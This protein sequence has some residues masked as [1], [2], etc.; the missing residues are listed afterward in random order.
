MNTI[1]GSIINHLLRSHIPGTVE[2]ASDM[3]RRGIS[4]ELQKQYR[5][6]GWL[7]LIG[8]GALVRPGE[9]VTWE[10]GLYSLQ[11]QAG[12]AVH[13]GALTALELHGVAHYIRSEQSPVYLFSTPDVTLPSWFRNHTWSQPVRHERTGFLPDDIGLTE[14]IL[15]LFSLHISSRERAMLEMLFLAPGAFDLMECYQVIEGLIALRPKLLQQLL[16]ACRSVKVKRLFLFM[17]EKANHPWF[18]RLNTG[19]IDIGRGKRCLVKDGTFV[20]KYDITV[21]RNLLS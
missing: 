7:E 20:K 2:L 5:K 17:A 19:S 1:K 8:T 4:Y 10:G 15:P 9:N 18:S 16:V 3:H 6:S 14:H 13:V 21:P 12:L 11:N